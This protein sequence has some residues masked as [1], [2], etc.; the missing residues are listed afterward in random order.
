MNQ[1]LIC[2]TPIVPFISFGRMPLANGFLRPEEFATEYFFDLQGAFCG[3]CG[4]VQL[5]E[6]PDREKMFNAN[7]A[8]YSGTSQGMKIHFQA[9]AEQVKREYLRSADPFVVEIGSNDGIMLENFA[10]QHIRHLGIEPS[11]NVAEVAR[12]KG[13]QTICEFFE[14]TLARQI[15]KEHGQA[16]ALLGANVMCHIPYLHSVLKGVKILLKPDGIMVF[17]DPYLGDVIE[18]TSYDQIYDEHVFLFSVTSISYL[19]QQHGMEIIEVIPQETHGGSMRYIVSH[20]GAHPIS[21][22]VLTYLQKEKAM[23]LNK[24][25][26]YDEFRKKVED[27]R[28]ALMTLLHDIKKMCKRIVGYAATSKSTTIINF[29]GITPDLI[30]F[31]SDTTPVKQGKYS[32]GA[33]IPV[34]PYEEFTARYPDYALLFAYNHAQEIMAK[35]KEFLTSGGRWITYV[36][37]VQVLT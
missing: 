33:H 15:V 35:E 3:H 12:Q 29:C 32:P 4:M 11:A 30:D 9:F 27:S 1:C 17:E 22:R 26:V 6:Q 18:K 7:Y 2:N 34:R 20:Q 16:D 10:R 28:H 23:G 8:F 37:K 25:A 24:P 21:P 36:P 19:F 14:E 5:L 13:V 31:I